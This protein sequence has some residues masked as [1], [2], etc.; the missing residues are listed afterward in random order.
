MVEIKPALLTPYTDQ[1]TLTCPSGHEYPALAGV[2]PFDPPVAA[3]RPRA[4]AAAIALGVLP[5]YL[6]VFVD[7]AITFKAARAGFNAHAYGYDYKKLGVVNH[8]PVCRTLKQLDDYF[9]GGQNA[10]LTHFGTGREKLRDLEIA[11]QTG[12]YR[13]P[14]SAVSQYLA[15]VGPVSPWAQGIINT[16]GNCPLPPHPIAT[17]LGSGVPNGAYISIENVAMS[18][19]DGVTDP[20]FNSNVFLRTIM[21]VYF[22]HSISPDTQVWHG[23]IDRVNRCS[24]PGWV[25]LEDPMQDAARALLVGDPSFLRGAVRID[26]PP[27]EPSPPPYNEWQERFYRLADEADQWNRDDVATVAKELETAKISAA[28]R[29]ERI[30]QIARG[31]L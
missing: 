18:G 5:A 6:Q 21:A 17:T 29:A 25:G 24:D 12:R 27:P 9:T 19:A 30:E 7:S 11:T 1:G 15:I 28:L 31:E 20:Q 8:I 13:V 3:W 23:E 2:C 14:V 10:G 4:G 22:N 16:G 26:E